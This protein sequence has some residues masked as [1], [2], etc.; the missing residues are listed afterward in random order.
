APRVFGRFAQSRSAYVKDAFH[1]YVVNGERAAVNPEHTGTKACLD[2]RLRIP[3]G[4]S[5]VLRLRLTPQRL[6][7]PL[8][9]VDDIVARRK[10]EADEFYSTVHTPRATE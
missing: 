9:E 10:A 1:R 4:Q 2:Y 7:D 8:H 5:S 6:D 3:P